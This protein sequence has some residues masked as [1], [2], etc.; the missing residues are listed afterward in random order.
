MA[1]L[2]SIAPAALGLEGEPVVDPVAEVHRWCATL[3]TVDAALVPDWQDVRDALLHCAPTALAPSVVHGDFRL[4]NLL[5]VGAGINA[6]I[7]WEIWSVGDRAHRCGLVSDQL[8]PG[9]LPA[10]ARFGRHR[11]AHRRTRRDLRPRRRL[12]RRLGLVHRVGVLQVGGDVVADRQAQPPKRF[13]AS[14]IGGHGAHAAEAAGTRP[15]NGG[16]ASDPFSGSATKRF[17]QT[18]PTPSELD[19]GPPSSD[20]STNSA[21][22]CVSIWSMIGGPGANGSASARAMPALPATAMT[23]TAPVKQYRAAKLSS[24]FPTVDHGH[25]VS[26]LRHGPCNEASADF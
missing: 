20:G 24:T 21:G 3:Q 23:L 9:H 17:S 5:A 16:L 22:V 7:D 26:V 6:I 18:I 15:V 25:P 11:A 19:A 13:A 2:H 12:G 10:G 1:A 14:R 4:G 8:R